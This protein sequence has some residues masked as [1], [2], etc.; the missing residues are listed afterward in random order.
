LF[1]ALLEPTKRMRFISRLSSE[2]FNARKQNDECIVGCPRGHVG[3]DRPG[4]I[5]SGCSVSE[6]GPTRLVGGGV[7]RVGQ[8]GGTG[9]T[10]FPMG[11]GPVGLEK[12]LNPIT[13]RFPTICS[14]LIGKKRTIYHWTLLTHLNQVVQ[15]EY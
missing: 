12:K 2:K 15:D 3:A 10:C 8:H 4:G 6:P 13:N 9:R 1:L 11:T 7:G 14:G 5:I